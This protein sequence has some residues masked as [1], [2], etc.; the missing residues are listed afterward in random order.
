MEVK[1]ILAYL[2]ANYDIKWPEKVY[3]ESV[4]GYTAEGYRPP[5][6]DLGFRMIPDR[7]PEMLIRRRMDA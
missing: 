7:T 4:P 1:L 5:D 2:V 3:N 6:L